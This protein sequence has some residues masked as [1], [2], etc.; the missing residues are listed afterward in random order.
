MNFK[1]FSSILSGLAASARNKLI[2]G[3]IV[4]VPLVVTIWVLHVIFVAIARV[5]RPL[6]APILKQS[7]RSPD[8]YLWLAFALTILLFLVLGLIATN[9]IGRKLIEAFERVIL[10][11]PVVAT[12]YSGIKQVM[13]SVQGLKAGMQF[14]RVVYVDYPATGYLLIGFVTGQFTD[15]QNGQEMTCVFLPTSPNPMT[16]F[17]LVVPSGH[18]KNCPLTLE[19]A[20]KLIISGGL[21]GP[22]PPPSALPLP[23]PV[24]PPVLA[25]DPASDTATQA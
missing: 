6:I 2:A 25:G 18:I 14:Q 9:V 13:D 11:V 20:T 24:Q 21:V 8:D 16:G 22:K 10:R 7:G 23:A 3:V 19:E 4:A 15:N 5:S 12:V 17:T 1:D